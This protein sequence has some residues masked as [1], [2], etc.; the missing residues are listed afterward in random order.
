MDKENQEEFVNEQL[1]IQEIKL[2]TSDRLLNRNDSGPWAIKAKLITNKTKKHMLF[3]AT[4]LKGA[5]YF[6]NKDFSKE[7][8][9]IR[10]RLK[11]IK[12]I[13]RYTS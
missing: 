8:Q 4:F 3:K 1:H 9:A 11:K 10:K 13:K 5:R 12:R 6:V 7:T 2:G